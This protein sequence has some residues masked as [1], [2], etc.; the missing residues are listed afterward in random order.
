MRT[1]MECVV[2]VTGD[3]VRTGGMD[4]PNFEVAQRLAD[5]GVSVQLVAFRVA[6]ELAK[7][8]NVHWW[9]VPKP[10]RSYSLGLPLLDHVGRKVGRKCLARG[11]R[12][13]VNGGNCQVGDVNWVHYVHAAYQASGSP[14]LAR[15][16]Q[17]ELT[18]RLNVAQE[19]SA[20]RMAGTVIVNS[21]RTRRDL[22]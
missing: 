14:S 19:R 7:H 1:A 12:V 2:L 16:A 21:E 4:M 22:T 20:L 6:D 10:L 3:F 13:I 15:R 18:N 11:G 5:C 9:R 17:H 8:T